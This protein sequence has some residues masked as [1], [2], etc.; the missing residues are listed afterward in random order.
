M[1]LEIINFFINMNARD[2]DNFLVAKAHNLE[3]SLP[4]MRNKV[5]EILDELYTPEVSHLTR[6]AE[7][8]KREYDASVVEL[9]QRFPE[10]MIRN[11]EDNFTN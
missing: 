2:F 10:I 7:E 9:Y 3:I 4:E 5:M 1:K 11:L 8:A 6:L